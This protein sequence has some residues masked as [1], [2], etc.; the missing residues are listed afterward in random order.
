MKSLTLCLVLCLTWLV[1]ASLAASVMEAE[2]EEEDSA[3]KTLEKDAAKPVMEAKQDQGNT[4][5]RRRK[6]KLLKKRKL[7]NKKESR[8]L[9][10]GVNGGLDHGYVQQY[11]QADPYDIA[12][13][14]SQNQ[15]RLPYYPPYHQGGQDVIQDKIFNQVGEA[16][17]GLFRGRQQGQVGEGG[18]EEDGEQSLVRAALPVAVLGFLS[19]ALS[20]FFT[21]VRS[22]NSTSNATMPLLFRLPFEDAKNNNGIRLQRSVDEADELIN[23]VNDN[24]S[25]FNWIAK[26]VT[27]LKDGMILYALM[28]DDDDCRRKIAC[29]FGIE[30]QTSEHR[31]QISAMMRS[32]MPKHLDDFTTTFFRSLNGVTDIETCS[33]IPC[34]KCFSA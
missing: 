5:K 23:L 29:I 32:Y 26:Y 9:D 1:V 30:A 21:N 33:S 7:N 25:N 3:L 22:V 28:E 19:L 24:N 14:E 8:R 31:D 11:K 15:V 27:R 4:K 16:V 2:A 17:S 12:A 18:E 13:I 20:S 34:T 6:K 10:L